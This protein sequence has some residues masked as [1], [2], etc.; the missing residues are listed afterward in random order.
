MYFII[1]WFQFICDSKLIL[2][3]VGVMFHCSGC[4]PACVF[5]IDI[6]LDKKYVGYLI[7]FG[8]FPLKR[9]IN[10]IKVLRTLG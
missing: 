3:L 1:S 6:I 4:R 9:Y 2:Y 10:M 5:S 8:H 7:I